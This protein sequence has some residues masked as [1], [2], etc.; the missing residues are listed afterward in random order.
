[1]LERWGKERGEEQSLRKQLEGDIAA[2]KHRSTLNPTPYTLHPT[3]YTLH[4]TPY[5]LTPHP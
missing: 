1:M 4:P 2:G 3:L 5:T